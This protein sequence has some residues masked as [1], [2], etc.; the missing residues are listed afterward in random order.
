KLHAKIQEHLGEYE[1]LPLVALALD[2]DIN[3]YSILLQGK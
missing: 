2:M 1:Q 3:A